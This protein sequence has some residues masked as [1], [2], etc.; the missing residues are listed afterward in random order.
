MQVATPQSLVAHFY[1]EEVTPERLQRLLEAWDSAMSKATNDA[2]SGMAAAEGGKALGPTFAAEIARAVETLEQDLTHSL[3]VEAILRQVTGA[4]LVV[5]AEMR[6]LAVNEAA[7]TIFGIEAGEGLA[8]LPLE[9][10]GIDRL[11][12]RLA[13]L[14][15]APANRED[16]VPL[17]WKGLDR[18]F[19][20]HIRT[21]PAQR[22]C[23]RFLL[24]TSEQAWPERLSTFMADFFR[25]TPAEIEVVRCLVAGGTVGAIAEATRRSAGTIRSQLHS[26]L[27]KTETESQADL[28][29]LVGLLRQSVEIDLSPEHAEAPS[30]PHHEFI[31]LRDGRRLEVLHFGDPNGAPV[32]RLQTFYG[33]FRFP[34]SAEND[35]ERRGLRVV[36]PMRA[37]W[38]GSD[39]APRGRDVLDLAVSDLRELMAQFGIEEAVLLTMGDDIR[40]ALMLAKA[41]PEA[42]RHIIAVGSGFPILNDAQYRRLMPV[43]RFVRACARYQPRMLPFMAKAF[44]ATMLRHGIEKYLRG[45]LAST[46]PA[47]G[48]AMSDPEIAEAVVAGTA[49]MYGHDARMEVACCA[50][51]RAFHEDWPVDLGNVACPVTLIHGAQ[52]GNAP[53]ATAQDYCALYP[54]WRLIEHPDEGQLVGYVRWREVFDLLGEAAGTKFGKSGETAQIPASNEV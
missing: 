45:M 15:L 1:D 33:Y 31:R 42:V 28:V 54:E 24:V 10:S 38:A 17:R 4:A 26:I 25:L 7:R 3:E 12:E 8:C 53:F 51:M 32:I 52:D 41:H 29:R 6:V 19:H 34:R 47:D 20:T 43:T 46:S 9:R 16:V 13:V 14:E 39:P 30:E 48:C 40:I 2:G 23:P 27:A 49:Y 35:L 22:G 21:L 36:V 18:I 37:G 11:A 5:S 50:E 44:R